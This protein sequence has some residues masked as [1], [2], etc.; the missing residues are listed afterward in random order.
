[1]KTSASLPGTR[2][3]RR[4][5]RKHHNAIQ[6]IALPFCI[7]LVAAALT[8]GCSNNGDTTNAAAATSATTA[9]EYACPNGTHY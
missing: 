7:T 6:S 9:D 4:A 2:I 1:M 3:S 8:L 5:A